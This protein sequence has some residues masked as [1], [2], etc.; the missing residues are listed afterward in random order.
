MDGWLSFYL[1][2]GKTKRLTLSLLVERTH[3]F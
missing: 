3:S 1:G 2:D